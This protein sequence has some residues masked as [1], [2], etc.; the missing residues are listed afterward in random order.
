MLVAFVLCSACTKGL[1][2]EVFNNSALTLI[3]DVGGR[4]TN[5]APQQFKRI[6]LTST[7]FEV[8]HGALTWKYFPSLHAPQVIS[9]EGHNILD[10]AYV[11]KDDVIKVQIDVDGHIYI[12]QRDQNFPIQNKLAQ[13]PGYP[14]AS[15]L[16]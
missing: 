14:L 7:S 1:S 5:I 8:Q 12:L 6:L 4:K 2:A 16:F 13:P 9:E 11:D 3:V 15:S 10:P